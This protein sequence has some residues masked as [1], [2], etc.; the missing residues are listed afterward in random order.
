MVTSVA[1][2]RPVGSSVAYGMSKAALN[3]LTVLLA[4]ACGP[5]RVNAVA[6]GLV[7]TPWTE[8]WE[9]MH[10]TVSEIA[11]V[12]RSAVPDDIAHAVMALVTNPYTTGAIM[13]GDGGLTQ[14]L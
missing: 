9:A 12:G 1:G 5:V 14:V 13:V 4:K 11:P 10:G 3:H 8:G 6:P 2:L 7:A